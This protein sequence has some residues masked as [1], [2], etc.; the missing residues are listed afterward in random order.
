MVGIVERDEALGMFRMAENP[1][2]MVDADYRVARRVHHQK[3][4]FQR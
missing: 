1:R 2:G 3:C 4:F